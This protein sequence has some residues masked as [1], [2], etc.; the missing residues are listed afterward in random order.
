MHI[1]LLFR[2]CLGQHIPVPLTPSV[3]LTTAWAHH[4]LKRT[5]CAHPWDLTLTHLGR[6]CCGT[7][8]CH[9][10][11]SFSLCFSGRSQGHFGGEVNQ[12]ADNGNAPLMHMAHAPCSHSHNTPVSAYTM[13]CH[14]AHPCHHALVAITRGQTRRQPPFLCLAPPDN[15]RISTTTITPNSTTTTTPD[16][17]ALHAPRR[18]SHC[19]LQYPTGASA[20]GASRPDAR[21]GALLPTFTA[22]VATAA[23]AVAHDDQGQVG[24]SRANELDGARAS[25]KSTTEDSGPRVD[26]RRGIEAPAQ[27]SSE[28][29]A[30]ATAV[31]DAETTVLKWTRKM[32]QA[33][34]TAEAFS[35]SLQRTHA[36]GNIAYSN[37]S[38]G[39]AVSRVIV[40]DNNDDDDHRL[41]PYLWPWAVAFRDAYKVWEGKTP[42]SSWLAVLSG[43][44]ALLN[45]LD[46][47]G[48]G[49]RTVI[50]G[51]SSDHS[52]AHQRSSSSS[53]D[54]DEGG[55]G[56]MLSLAEAF[57]RAC[58]PLLMERLD[59][60]DTHAIKRVLFRTLAHCDV[61][62]AGRAHPSALGRLHHN[63]D[64]E[65]SS[66]QTFE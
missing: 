44:T 34:S 27:H 45:L 66:Y 4:G 48:S 25:T 17:L 50:A 29:G 33:S 63:I 54:G 13:A 64:L 41:P 19:M 11:M 8:M 35:Q 37:D 58:E 14:F 12:H 60:S 47:A 6:Y 61:F 40:D 65:S 31:P 53:L 1:C 3:T 59:E 51:T 28:R 46:A 15:T 23:A 2:Q 55:A 7:E 42:P 39:G 56:L 32:Q 21:W 5:T 49:G 10:T 52:D 20:V 26:A 43:L 24:A 62:F 38:D 30:R 22:F 18:T 36:R 57:H 9:F 16:P